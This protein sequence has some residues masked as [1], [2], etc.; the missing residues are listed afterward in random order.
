MKIYVD[1][2]ACPKAIKDILFKAARRTGIE[3]LLVANQRLSIPAAR[4]IKMHQVPQGIDVADQFIAIECS[5]DDLVITA[6]IPL[7]DII[8]SKGASALNPR[9]ELYT[10]ENIKLRLG[11]R[12]IMDELRGSGVQTGGP[13]TM[14]PRD[15]QQFANALDRWLAKYNKAL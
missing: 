4:N 6:D 12:N 13:K 15:I 3:L 9:G 11:V 7:A 10:E 1:A 5:A 2:D 14:N 8:V